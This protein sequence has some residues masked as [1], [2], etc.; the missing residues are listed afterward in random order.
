MY[1]FDPD[2]TQM[3][4]ADK[5]Q[6]IWAVDSFLYINNGLLNSFLDR[7]DELYKF[8][9][10]TK[11]ILDTIVLEGPQGDFALPQG[12]AYYV[13]EDN[14]VLLTGEW[15]DFIEERMKVFLIKL[16]QDLNIEW[17][18]YYHNISEF[19]LYANAL[20]QTTDGNIMIYASEVVAE[21][22]SPQLVD[23]HLIKT[24]PNGE[25][26]WT[27]SIPDTFRVFAG[28]GDIVRV[29]NGG[30][31]IT[32][33]VQDWQTHPS[34][35]Y[36]TLIHRI[37]EDGDVIWSRIMDYVDVF[38][39]SGIV[40]PLAN[41]ES[42]IV[43]RKDTS[44]FDWITVIDEFPVLYGL[45]VDGN[46]K[47]RHE[48]YDVSIRT[49]YR[50]ITANNGDIL[51]MGVYITENAPGKVWLFRSTVDGEIKWERHYSDSL[52]RPWAP[53][54]EMLDFTEMDDGRIAATGI[55]Y[56]TNRLGD[57]N[58]NIGLLVVDSNGC[59]EPDCEGVGQYITSTL[60][61]L[62]NPIDL[63]V[64]TI[65]PN[66]VIYGQFAIQITGKLQ[67]RKKMHFRAF[68]MQG[69][70]VHSGPVQNA[71]VVQIDCGDWAPGM[72][73]LL[74]YEGRIPVAAGKIIVA[75]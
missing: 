55:V 23:L 2:S 58:F 38:G 32:G 24:D 15:Y 48:W 4:R 66:P 45:D 36:N 28:N 47:W 31:L 71:S 21:S 53:I 20:S 25:I 67:N 3:Y 70:I 34:D 37:S 29:T 26:I 40:T 44:W 19:N 64:L 56:D 59:I 10:N 6:N 51:G 14:D 65:L 57:I 5:A 9:S 35:P 72:Y 7:Y 13:T 8:N 74:L 18:K 11:S 42:A 1:S 52:I 73:Q 27:K 41:G 43:W 69:T 46:I 16:D 17:A 12:G 50:I 62:K 75:R 63:D 68:N 61:L 49:V 60:D 39:Q 33:F 22:P 54:L 30:F